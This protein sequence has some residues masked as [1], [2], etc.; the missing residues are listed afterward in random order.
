MPDPQE[1]AEIAIES[2]GHR[3]ASIY[4]PQRGV[5]KLF[6]DQPEW[7]T[8]ASLERADDDY[9]ARAVRP[10]DEK[11]IR[12]AA[13]WFTQLYALTNPQFK[14]V[15]TAGECR[16]QYVDYYAKVVMHGMRK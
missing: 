8:P 12:K 16:E 1:S 3:V 6:I 15:L 4:D 5:L 14:R 7:M 2:L 11:Q 10:S 13:R 9:R